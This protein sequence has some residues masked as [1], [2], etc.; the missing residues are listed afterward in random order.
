M[1][2]KAE[3]RRK[4]QRTRAW[5]E[6]RK[7]IRTRYWERLSALMFKVRPQII[8]AMRGELVLPSTWEDLALGDPTKDTIGFGMYGRLK[9]S[10]ELPVFQQG[11]PVISSPI[12]CLND[13]KTFQVIIDEGETE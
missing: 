5:K 10:E 11:H 6:C 7:R 9:G 1:A 13:T 8:E 3:R 2:S 4:K 12:V